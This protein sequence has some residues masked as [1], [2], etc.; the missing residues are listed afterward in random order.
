MNSPVVKMLVESGSVGLAVCLIL[1]LASLISWVV[2][3][4][5]FLY[6]NAVGSGVARFKRAFEKLSS[7]REFGTIRESLRSSYAGILVNSYIKE[8][9]R[10]AIDLKNKTG[11]KQEFYFEQQTKIAQEKVDTETAK[12]AQKLSWGLHILAIMASA[13]PF[14]GLFGTVWGIMD[15]FFEIGEKGSASLTVV[16]PGIAIALIT[17]VAGLLVA[18]PA[19]VCYNL[20]VKKAEKIEDILDSCSDLGFA[21]MKEELLYMIDDQPK[22]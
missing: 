2:I 20:F 12:Y 11:E 15:S 18:I 8:L 17:T 6:L 10:I 13:A 4:N 1:L 9:N 21:K 5:R 7:L 22:S 16:A 14:V 19:V 3:I